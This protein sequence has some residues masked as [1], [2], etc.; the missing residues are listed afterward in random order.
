MPTVTCGSH[1]QRPMLRTIEQTAGATWLP[2]IPVAAGGPDDD[3]RL[4]L[5]TIEP[6]V[7]N[8]PA[9]DDDDR[10]DH[11]RQRP[12]HPGAAG[13]DRSEIPVGDT[14]VQPGVEHPG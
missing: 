12:G 3:W 7:R 13:C 10:P 4:R 14:R 5:V 9:A 8:H 11:E 1:G 6:V 2:L